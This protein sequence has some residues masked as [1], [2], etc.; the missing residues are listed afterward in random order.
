MYFVEIPEAK[1]ATRVP[2]PRRHN[3]L[4]APADPR[5]ECLLPRT[6]AGW[7]HFFWTKVLF[8][9]SAPGATAW[10]WRSILALNLVTASLLF[11]CL[12]FHL[13]EPDEGRYAQI[14]RE[15]LERGDWI[16][17]TLQGQPY[18]DKP[19]L[20]YWLVMASFAVFGYQGWAARLVPALAMQGTVLMSYLL[21]RRLMG[22]RAAFLGALTLALMPGL[23]MGKLLVLDGLLTFFATVSI[24]CGYLAATGVRLHWG[25]WLTAALACGLGVLTKGPIALLLLLPPLCL[26][27]WLTG[28]R[29]HIGIRGWLAFAGTIL[30]VTLPWY[31]AACLHLPDFARHFLWEHNVVR[32]LE[33]FDHVRPV[34][35]YLPILVGGLLPATLLLIPFVRFLLSTRDENAAARGPALGYLLLAGGWCVLFFSLSGCKLPTYILPAFPLLAL[36][37]GSFLAAGRWDRSRWVLGVALAWWG[38]WI[39]IHAAVVPYVAKVRSPLNNSELIKAQCADPLVPVVCFPRNIDSVAFHLGRSDFR[40]FRSKELGKMVEFLNAQPRTVILCGHRNSLGTLAH[41]LPRHLRIRESQQM[42]LCHLAVVERISIRSKPTKRE[43][44]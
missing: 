34:W 4:R 19:P 38:A 23:A 21:G 29:A 36:A 18:L 33:P 5:D 31:V 6:M 39:V 17:P 32:F 26:Q 13:F 2:E 7:L 24:L 9:G 44:D 42:G 20:F 12:S 30:A 22:E 3:I 10:R 8:P 1:P 28:A 14:P 35:F 15:M 11:P 43:L 40:S 41:H 37:C 16:V 27:R 25:W